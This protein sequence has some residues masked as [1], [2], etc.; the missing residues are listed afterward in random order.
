MRRK[1]V[2]RL[3]ILLITL[4]FFVFY[5]L[6]ELYIGN[7]KSSLS[8]TE[9][10]LE[11]NTVCDLNSKPCY[12]NADDKRLELKLIGNLKTMQ[13][14]NLNAELD[15]FSDVEA[16]FVIF[17]M[18]SMN[19][20]FNQYEFT[21]S[22]VSPN[23]SPLWRASIILPVCTS[24]RSDWEMLFKIVTKNDVYKKTITLQIE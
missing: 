16:V 22:G 10:N 23:A 4:I 7:N 5:I 18:V 2:F 13:R 1:L 14:F 11:T 8:K 21:K 15:N 12:L 20:G 9:I 17:S 3:S 24:K 6:N 19:M